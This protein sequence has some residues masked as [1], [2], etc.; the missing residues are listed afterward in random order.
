M[1]ADDQHLG[2]LRDRLL[3]RLVE[4]GGV[5]VLGQQQDLDAAL[6]ERVHHRLRAGDAAVAALARKFQ[7]A[8]PSEDGLD[9]QVMH[10]L[11]TDLDDAELNALLEEAEAKILGYWSARSE[12][13]TEEDAKLFEKTVAATEKELRRRFVQ[14]LGG[15]VK[16]RG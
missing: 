15:C 13:I 10:L 3:D 4:L 12:E 11:A 6:L 14:A 9:R 8:E 2:G 5:E 16:T 7:A 1:V